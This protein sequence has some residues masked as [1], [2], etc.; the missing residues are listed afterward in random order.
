MA[1][2]DS[3]HVTVERARRLAQGLWILWAVLVWNVIFDQVV[4]SAARDYIAAALTAASTGRPYVLMDAW[5][6]PAIG[7]GIAMASA[8]A[9]TILIVGFTALRFAVIP[10]GKSAS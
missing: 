7:R 10:A 3:R 9:G 2:G 5:M 8:A 6:R 4:V 1:F